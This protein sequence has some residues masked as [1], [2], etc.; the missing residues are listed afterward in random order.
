MKYFLVQAV[1]KSQWGTSNSDPRIVA[2]ED[3]VGAAKACF[4]DVSVVYHG[5]KKKFPLFFKVWNQRTPANFADEVGPLKLEEEFDE[6]S[7]TSYDA[8]A[9]MFEA[10]YIEV[11]L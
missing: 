11:R 4:D 9:D 2:A 7:K 10:K 3:P 6:D 8:V 5:A 1:M